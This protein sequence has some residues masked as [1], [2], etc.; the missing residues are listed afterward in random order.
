MVLACIECKVNNY[1]SIQIQ[2]KGDKTIDMDLNGN[3][4]G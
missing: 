3:I 4:V 1:P 2:N